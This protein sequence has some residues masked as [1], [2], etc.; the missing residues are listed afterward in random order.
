MS[1]RTAIYAR[2][3]TTDQADQG[4]SLPS[5]LDSCRRYAERVGCTITAEFSEDV[6]GAIPVSNRPQGSQLT[7][8]IKRRQIDA[9]IVHQVDRLSRDIVDLL[10]TVRSW[11]Q[12]GIE[13]YAGDVGKIE[14]ELDI[15]LIIKG[16]Q[17]SDERKKIRERSMRGK[18]AKAKAGKV[19]GTRPPYGYRHIRDVNG[20]VL[21]FELV[22]EEA[23]VIRMIFQWYVV[24]DEEG[25]RLAGN[26]IARR[27]SELH[28]LTPG[29][30]RAGYHRRRESGMWQTDKVLKILSHEVYAGVWH[31]G[32]RIG[33]S[34]NK[35]P[36]DEWI[37]VNVPPI[38]ERPIWEAAQI[39]MQRN[40]EFAK[41]NA[42]H[43]YLLS[44]LIN[45]GCGCAL[46]GEYFS[47]HRYYSC[48]RRQNRHAGLEPRSCRANSVRADAIEADVWDSI[49]NLF[50]DTPELERLLRIAQQEELLAIDPK[51]Q[52]LEA[53][54]G[55]IIDTERDAAEVGQA[56][57]RATGIVSR[58]LEQDMASINQRYAALSQHRDE[59]QLEVSQVRLTDAAIDD[60]IRFA[61]DVRLG[62]ENADFETKR[63]HLEILQVRT[64]VKDGRY[65]VNCL[66]GEWDG[67]IRKLPAAP[68]GWEAHW[69]KL[70]GNVVDDGIVTS[71]RLPGEDPPGCRFLAGRPPPVQ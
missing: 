69:N 20:K 42:K 38:V 17:G 61:E 71:S 57:K 64:T 19:V 68:S 44:G 7:E 50:A 33:N 24:G 54:E 16:W 46:C 39:Q 14:S 12:S 1:K 58:A 35:R 31:Y 5:Q 62:I 3:S 53:I 23:Q 70:N 41:R 51:R 13:V 37:A 36:S 29:E 66:A 21:N 11:L 22:E 34:I 67:E 27:L 65:Y 43:D 60:A 55:M 63:R 6:S 18:S 59:L 48:S 8:M 28:I 56:L 26:A 47:D 52:E 2:V 40:K 15:V 49:V 25:H 9:V 45:C 30:T 32:M 4:Y 10:V